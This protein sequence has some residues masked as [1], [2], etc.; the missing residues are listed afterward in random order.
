MPFDGCRYLHRGRR[1]LRPPV[2]DGQ[3]GHNC[4]AG[5]VAF[6]AEDNNRRPILASLHG[7]GAMLVDM[8]S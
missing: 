1:I 6:D 7:A 8:N 5:L 4:L 2:R 3:N